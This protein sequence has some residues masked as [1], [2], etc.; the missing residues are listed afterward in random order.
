M[1]QFRFLTMAALIAF[2]TAVCAQNV[3]TLDEMQARK[4]Q[5]Q[6]QPQQQ[7]VVQE[8]VS[9]SSSSDNEAFGT[10]F[11]QYNPCSLK[12][13]YKGH[14]ASTSYHG[15]SLGYLYSMPLADFPLYLEFGGAVQYAFH[16]ETENSSDK[17]Y[18]YDDY[19]WDDFGGS[20]HEYKIKTYLL[21]VRIPIGVMYSF[22]VS[23][24]FSIQPYAGP[25]I[26]ANI[27]AKS[28]YTYDGKSET[29]DLFSKDDTGDNAL[30][31]VQ[32]GIQVGC[33]FRIGQKFTVGGGYFRDLTK[34][35]EHTH[36]EGF[37]ITL[38]LNF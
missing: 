18:D 20:S 23:D 12:A 9:Y 11:L 13:S 25:Y 26:R 35:Q 31:R 36:V 5:Q 34:I 6:Q 8:K 37:D 19:G 32:V 16:N 15:F 24:A 3:I 29:I 38:G 27:L 7:Q 30:K 10:L 2:G 4:K 33:K 22:D 14:S 1:K 17:Y 21:S 28:K